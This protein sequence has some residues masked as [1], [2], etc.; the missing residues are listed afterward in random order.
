MEPA[1][2]AN[3][4]PA[5]GWL[6]DTASAFAKAQGAEA[7]QRTTLEMRAGGTHVALLGT[8]V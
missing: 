2:L 4:Q 5:A 1:L 6:A 3:A 8:Q 7:E